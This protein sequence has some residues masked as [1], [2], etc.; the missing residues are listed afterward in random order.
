MNIIF[1]TA[2]FLSLFTTV[3]FAQNTSRQ[4]SARPSPPS[5]ATNRLEGAKLQVCQ[6]RESAIKTRSERLIQLAATMQER[7]DA[8][9][10]RVKEYYTTRLLTEGK[11]VANYDSLVAQVQTKKDAVQTSLTNAQG[12][13]TFSCTDSNPKTALMQFN[14]DMRSVL[15]ALQEYRTAIKNLIVSINSVVG[16]ENRTNPSTGAGSLNKGSNK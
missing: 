3:A 9:S 16:V 13:T 1:I 7:F 12:D 6:L 4:P 11:T 15:T 2:I 10:E 14:E 5:Q 8:T